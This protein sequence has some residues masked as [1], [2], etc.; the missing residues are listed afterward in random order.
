MPINIKKDRILIGRL[1]FFV[2]TGSFALKMMPLIRG[3]TKRKKTVFIIA[4]MLSAWSLGL[5]IAWYNFFLYIPII[6]IIAS[7]PISP[8]GLGVVE[9]FFL[10][11]FAVGVVSESEVLALALV[12]RFV[13]MFCSLPGLVVALTGPKLPRAEQIRAELTD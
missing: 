1:I 11:F 10:A 6:Y 2:N 4:I 8:G 12:A 7:V 13:P 3:I 9:F 5:D